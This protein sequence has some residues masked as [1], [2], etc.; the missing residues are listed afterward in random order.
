MENTRALVALANEF[1]A[2]SDSVA[3][4]LVDVLHDLAAD[5]LKLAALVDP[6][7]NAEA[8]L[9]RTCVERARLVVDFHHR[10]HGPS[11]AH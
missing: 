5:T 2:A 3:H 8:E 10:Q 6:T 11:E 9:L 7:D 4:D 1:V